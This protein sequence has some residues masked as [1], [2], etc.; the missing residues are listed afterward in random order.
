[1][2]PFTRGYLHK[3]IFFVIFFPCSMLIIY[4]NGSRALVASLIFSLSLIM[5]YGVSAL[6][7][8]NSWNKKTYLLLRRLDHAAIFVLIA[9][10]ATPICLLK[11]NYKL[12][13]Q[14]LLILWII[15]FV[16]ILITTVWTHAPRL[17]RGLFY[18]MMGWVGILFL[19]ELKISL[20]SLDINLLIIGGVSYS[21]GAFIY[22]F[23]WPNP[24][25]RVFG[26]HEIFHILVVV[27]TG[28]HFAM[29]YNISTV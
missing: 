1:M 12:G 14:L 5:Q 4:S 8:T 27:G 17:V 16:G 10:S 19:P 26:Y 28:F 23:Q 29:N 7:H 25:P 22:M 2:K 11:L 6:Y 9:G 13:V 3:I 15:A 20:N 18:I 24:F 21:I